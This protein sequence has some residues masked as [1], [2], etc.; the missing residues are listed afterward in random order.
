VQSETRVLVQPSVQQQPL[1]FGIVLR[2][3]GKLFKLRIVGLL[4]FAATGGAFLGAAGQPTLGE[5]G[6]LFLTGGLSAAGASALNQFIERKKDA[7]MKRTRNRPLVNGDIPHPEWV[8]MIAFAMIFIP[9]LTV[10]F[11]N[12]ML[13]VFNLLGA[14]IYVV[15]YTL[16]LKPRTVL[17]IV[18]GG[19]AG[20]CAVLSGG[21]A[22]GAW[23]DPGVLALAGILFLWTP[24][25]FWSLAI[26]CREDYSRADI[27]MLP[28][29]ATPRE[30]AW[31]G[32]LHA[33]STMLLAILLSAHTALGFVYF[34]PVLL[35]T[36]Y[37]MQ[38]SVR[39]VVRPESK[40]ALKHF[41]TSN[42]Y[43]TVILTFICIASITRA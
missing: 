36:L 34:I 5:L 15:I 38:Q 33:G 35:I 39:L 8:L 3:I 40:Q 19:A 7:K 31:W 28:A 42:V 10:I 18:I 32:L 9:A 2:I 4:L 11:Y 41:L 22:V 43:L 25:H 1:T 12:P 27:P 21:A 16:W 6:I 24:T 14:F 29:R 23:A 37:F 20:S 30:S 13:A 26:V 17:N